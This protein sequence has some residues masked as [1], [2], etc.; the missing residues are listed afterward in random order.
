MVDLSIQEI[1]QPIDQL[2]PNYPTAQVLPH[3]PPQYPALVMA[4]AVNEPPWRARMKLNLAAPLH[5]LPNHP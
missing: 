1:T 2:G 4:T 3:S 5:D